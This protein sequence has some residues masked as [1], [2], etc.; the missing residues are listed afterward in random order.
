[1]LLKMRWPALD[2]FLISLFLTVGI[3]ACRQDHSSGSE[4]ESAYMEDYESPTGKW[5]FLNKDGKVAIRPA[6]DDVGFFSEGLAAVN[7]KG[8]WGF[9]NLKGKQVIKPAFRSAWAFHEKK[10]RVIPFDQPS[11]FIDQQGKVLKAEG[12]SAEDD[13]SEGRA[14]VKV[15]NA[16]GYIDSTGSIVI[17]PVYTRGWNFRKGACIVEFQEK[18]GVIDLKGSF[19]LQPEFNFIKIAG[20]QNIFLCQRANDAI[21]FDSNGKELT[22]LADGKMV[23]CDGYLISVRDKEKMYLFDLSTQTQINSASF[24]NIIYLEDHL[25]AGK[26]KEG[27]MLL[28]EKG[29][30][31][32]SA[33]YEQINK[34]S[35]GLAAFRKGEYWGYMDEK[36]IERTSDIFGLAWDYREGLARAA[37]KDGIGF[38]DAHQKLAFSPPE[39]SIDLR[40]FAEGMAAIRFQ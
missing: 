10:A 27:Y 17:Q 26:T 29:L 8:L 5:G 38:I 22:K 34:F 21:A 39:G 20:Q 30:P 35:E 14:R 1:M 15:G 31:L 18:L 40:D 6:F 33:T 7:Q 13:F 36:G 25:W 11:R 23:D 4:E 16:F 37:F 24:V 9:I 12:W 28:D 19:I 3:A 32:T 2:L